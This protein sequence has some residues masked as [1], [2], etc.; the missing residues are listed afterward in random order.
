MGKLNF[1]KSVLLL[2]IISTLISCEKNNDIEVNQDNLL[3]G[4]WIHP[5]YENETITFQRA[6]SLQENAYGISF[7]EKDVF[8]ERTSGWCGT[9]PLSFF[10]INGT[11]NVEDTIISMY[12]VQTT[13][14]LPEP[15]Y[16]YKIV[17][18]T[19]NQLIVKTALTAQEIDHQ[20][21]MTLFNEVCELANSVSCTNSSNW[22][23]TSYGSKACG[24]PQGFIAYSNEIDTVAF[25]NAVAVYTE[26]ERQYN[27]KWSVF[28][29][30]DIPQQPTSV[31]CQNGYPVL[32]Y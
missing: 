26:A 27:I 22:N 6:N 1:K 28:S 31:E 5:E 21:L 3:L 14:Y 11:W 24:G 12:N 32:N 25:L 2:L 7:K 23:F 30:C 15:I 18:L 20:N 10:D 8:I 29:T 16:N 17:S 19:K 13:L 4:N 9:P